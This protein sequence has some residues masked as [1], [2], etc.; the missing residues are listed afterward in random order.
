MHLSSLQYLMIQAASS[1]GPGKCKV[2]LKSGM[3]AIF[4]YALNQ[5]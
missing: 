1:A 3:Y 4:M 5:I 2:N